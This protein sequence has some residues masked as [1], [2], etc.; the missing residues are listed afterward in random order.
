MHTSHTC[1]KWKDTWLL[2]QLKH[3]DQL[4]VAGRASVVDTVL[5]LDHRD[6]AAGDEVDWLVHPHA[7]LQSGAFEV[8]NCVVGVVPRGWAARGRVALGQ[9]LHLRGAADGIVPADTDIL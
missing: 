5:P 7:V 2:I 8:A 9:R 3:T 4:L 1:S 6:I